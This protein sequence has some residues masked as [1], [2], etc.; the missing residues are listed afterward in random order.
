LGSGGSI[1]MPDCEGEECCDDTGGGGGP[2][3]GIGF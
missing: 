2:T 3:I 1:C